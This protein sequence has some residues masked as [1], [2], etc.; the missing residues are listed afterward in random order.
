MR[1]P[2]GFTI[3][4]LLVVIAIIMFLLAFM[5]GVFLR[6]NQ[7]AKVKAT[8]ALI[9]KI[10]MALTQYQADF[11]N[12][13]P[14]SG[15]GLPQ[16]GGIVGGK[17]MYDRGDAVALLYR[18]EL[19]VNGQ[20]YGPYTPRSSQY[21]LL[22]IIDANGQ[23]CGLCSS[24]MPGA[25]RSVTSAIPIASCTIAT[26]STFSPADPTARRPAT[27]GSTTT[28]TARPTVPSITPTTEPGTGMS[29]ELGEAML[30]GC[31]TSF[32]KNPE[33]R[34]STRRHQQLGSA[35]LNGTNWRTDMKPEGRILWTAAG[36]P[37]YGERGYTLIE[38][39]VVM[40]I[41]LMMTTLALVSVTSMLRSTRMSRGLNLLV[42]A[43]DEARTAA[44]TLRRST[45]VDLTRLD[46]EGGCNRLTIVGPFVNENFDSY[47]TGQSTDLSALWLTTGAPPEI[48]CDGSRCLK[49]DGT[50]GSASYWYSRMR[51]GLTGQDYELLV[52]ARVKFLNA[53]NQSGN[54]SIALLGSIDDGGGSA[55]KTAYRMTLAINPFNPLENTQST[56]TLDKVGGGGW[57]SERGHRFE[58]R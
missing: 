57:S 20:S 56:V 6:A 34:R 19:T 10:G 24:S 4:E 47:V 42:S 35:K 37:D 39:L 18:Q 21:E 43:A 54:R 38:L 15:F 36:R 31:L 29:N 11:R 52:Q 44:I 32:R 26:A 28:A 17:V 48:V 51:V 46:T 8:A 55:I 12:V 22:P 33:G 13:P 27:T 30:N 41:V 7:Q 58:R 23:E 50:G 40:G 1:K 16:N 5:T 14:D 45:R 2:R 53:E 49:M 3:I 25:R 9:Q